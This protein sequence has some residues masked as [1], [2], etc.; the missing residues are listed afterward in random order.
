MTGDLFYNVPEDDAKSESAAAKRVKWLRREI[1][2]HNK[3]YYQQNKPEI[4]DREYDMLVEELAELERRFP[5]LATAASPT[6]RVGGAPTGEFAQ[7]THKA[8][9]LSIANTYSH[10]ELRDFDGRV[11]KLLGRNDDIEYLVELK[12]DGVAVALRYESGRIV[13]GATRGDGLR[14]DVITDNL[15]KVRGVLDALPASSNRKGSVFEVRGEVYIDKA[16]FD[17]LNKQMTDTGEECFA[18]PRNLAAGSLKQKNSAVTATRPLRIFHYAAGATDFALPRTHSDFMKLLDDMGLRTNPQRTLCR[19]IEEAIGCAIEWEPKRDGLPYNIDGLV[20]KVN[21]R[22]WWDTLGTTAKTPRYM[23]AYKFSAKQAVTRLLDIQC[24]VGR[25]GVVTPVAHLEP[26]FLAGSTISRATLHNA[27]EIARLDAR[28]GDQ[29]VIEKAGDIIPRVVRVIESVR[30]GAERKFKF[31]RK[32]PI[33]GSELA[34]SEYEVAIRCPNISCSGQV[35]ERILY[36]GSRNGMDI[37]GLGGVIVNQLVETG[38]TRDIADLYALT[39]EPVASLER[40]AATSAANLI[41]KIEASKQRPLH[42]LLYALGIPQIGTSGARALALNYRAFEDLM[43]ARREE[44]SAIRDIGEVTAEGI[45]SFFHDASNRALIT[46]LRRA[47]VAAPNSL[48][49][50]A[51]A[52]A[53]DAPAGTFQGM[54]VVLTGTLAG[55]TRFDAQKRIEALGGKCSGSVSKKTSL[56]IAGGEAGSKLAKARELGVRVMGEDEFM[57]MLESASA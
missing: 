38:L 25:T 45:Y 21:R 37:E 9:M 2:R 23:T 3:F 14:G 34:R 20:V 44:L 18:N 10:E 19:S 48:Y 13:Y 54:T 55:M 24:Q 56:V 16:D 4:S 47:G 50:G 30:T 46:R 5:R 51:P 36:Y 8:P 12:I 22:E 49:R 43:E 26:V 53:S 28:I 31:P 32:C 7:I 40:M 17:R 29:V 35:R 27:D 6:Q 1:E 57:K 15:R 42:N 41:K 52:D 33:C 39:V 11:K